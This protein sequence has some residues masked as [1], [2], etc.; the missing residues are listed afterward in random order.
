MAVCLV[1]YDR[2][3][4]INRKFSVISSGYCGCNSLIKKQFM[5]LS[6]S[7]FLDRVL[8]IMKHSYNWQQ[9]RHSIKIGLL[10]LAGIWVHF[11]LFGLIWCHTPNLRFTGEQ[12][13]QLWLDAVIRWMTSIFA[14]LTNTTHRHTFM[15]TQTKGNN[16]TFRQDLWKTAGKYQCMTFKWSLCL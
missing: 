6:D 12:V 10:Q 8:T 16:L 3:C 7:L 14:V 4:I 1:N 9:R 15:Y 2:K 5:H 13:Q 11:T